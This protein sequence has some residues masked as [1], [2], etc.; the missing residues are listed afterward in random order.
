MVPH[1][2]CWFSFYSTWG[3][4]KHHLQI[5]TTRAT[6]GTKMKRRT[7]SST[8][9][10]SLNSNQQITCSAQ[11]WG[12]PQLHQCTH[13]PTTHDTVTSSWLSIL[14]ISLPIWPELGTDHRKM[15]LWI[16]NV[17]SC[18]NFLT[19]HSTL[20]VQA[21]Y[22]LTNHSTMS[23]PILNF[24]TFHLTMLVRAPHFLTNYLTKS[25]PAPHF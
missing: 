9:S 2:K 24:L 25:V 3:E 16:N 4:V 22:F 11:I 12:C 13:S 18:P 5:S 1:R 8:E 17:S 15:T 23:V 21:P 14:Y 10:S 7:S 20:L 6:N 19:D